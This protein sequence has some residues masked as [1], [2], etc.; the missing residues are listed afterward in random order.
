MRLLLDTHVLIWAV[1]EPDRLPPRVAKAVAAP[2]NAVYVSAASAWEIAIKRAAGRL[3]FP[4]DEIDEILDRAA[5]EPLPV[6]IAHGVAAGALPRHHGDP[7]DRL[8]VAQAQIED[9]VLVST[10]E[11]M[12]RYDVRL[13]DREPR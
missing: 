13:F 1:T 8:L 7:F 4:I 2:R 3:I 10:D 6:S 12:G 11:T 9:L 5:M